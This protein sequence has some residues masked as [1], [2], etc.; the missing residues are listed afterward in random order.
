ML[1]NNSDYVW[2]ID[3]LDG[4]MNFANGIPLFA[5][6]IALACQNE[7]KVGVVYNPIS[8]SMFCAE[9][10]K[11]AYLNDKRIFVSK[12]GKDKGII[13]TGSSRNSEDKMLWKSLNASLLN[14][15]RT[16]RY[17]ACAALDLAYVA[18]GG[19]EASILIGLHTY[20][21]AAGALLVK[22]A[23]GTIVN[24]N[25]DPWQFPEKKIIATNGLF[26]N[27]LVEV[28]KNEKEKLGMN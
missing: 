14:V 23:G 4:T 26:H 9:L 25:G 13:V 11:G 28:I 27:D 6:S 3:P 15:V 18:R 21:F 16:F 22:E 12:D 19:L 1:E 5:I 20:D 8:D 24:F 7:L 10:G 17:L 2:Y